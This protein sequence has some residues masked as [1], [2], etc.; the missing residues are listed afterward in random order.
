VE[1]NN[2]EDVKKNSKSIKISNV[3]ASDNKLQVEL[4]ISGEI[5]KYFFKNSFEVTYD[6]NIEDV[7]ESILAIPA[8]CAIVQVAWA[9]GADLYVEKT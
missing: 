2:T 7:D 8:V 6:R 4:D 1:S 5:T 9:T 3:R